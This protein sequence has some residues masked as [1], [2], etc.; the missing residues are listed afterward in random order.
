MT[1]KKL[2]MPG[3]AAAGPGVGAGLSLPNGASTSD[4]VV[5]LT[6]AGLGSGAPGGLV[7]NGNV[8]TRYQVGHE[9]KVPLQLLRIA[10]SNARVRYK[11]KDVHETVESLKAQGQLVACVGYFDN[12]LIYLQEGGK[13]LHCAPAAGLGELRVSMCER[14]ENFLVAYAQSRTMNKVRSAQT[15][16]DDAA[17]WSRILEQGL[18]SSQS[19]LA[20]HLGIDRSDVNRTL[21]LARIPSVIV[22]EMMEVSVFES[23]RACAEIARLFPED[24]GAAG[25]KSA[26]ENDAKESRVSLV[27]ALIQQA[28]R[29]N[30]G[31]RDVAAAVKKVIEGPKARVRGASHEYDYHGKKAV[32]KHVP[33]RGELVMSITGLDESRLDALHKELKA[34]L[35]TKSANS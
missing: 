33:E 22:T 34:V 32:I 2:V 17:I 30:W 12:G 18:V 24:Q 16:F 29:E 26:D 11:K 28:G 35:E 4:R 3:P 25:E 21:G 13:R 31:W 10:P 27:L 14:E 7:A 15:P 5:A 9:Y 1:G 6:G 23:L 8:D 20:E 19:E